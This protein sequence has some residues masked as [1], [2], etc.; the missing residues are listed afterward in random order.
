MAIQSQMKRLADA[1]LVNPDAL[2]DEDRDLLEQLTGDEVTVLI[3]IVT[4]LYPEARS[5]V[6][7]GDLS[8]SLMRICVPL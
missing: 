5:M 7:V 2:E 4:R 1:G 8:R 6:K 3:Q